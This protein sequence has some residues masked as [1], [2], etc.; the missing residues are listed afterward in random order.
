MLAEAAL[1]SAALAALP[2][3][4]NAQASVLVGG[5][6]AVPLAGF[7]DVADVGFQVEGGGTVPLGR[8]GV[9]ARAVAFYGRNGHRIA[10]DRSELYG[11]TVLG[12]YAVEL[13]SD[14]RLTPWIG[15]GGAVHARKSESFPGLDASRRGLTLTGGGTV[16][17]GVGRVR[18]LASVFY[19]RGVGDLGGDAYPTQLVT[20]GGGLEIPL[21]ID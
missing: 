15:I 6:A 9:L 19:V 5:G 4:V 11:V 14:V 2:A 13:G 16:S 10:G 3:G 1:L 18:V 12:G 8:A 17:R 21:G 7:G 20:V